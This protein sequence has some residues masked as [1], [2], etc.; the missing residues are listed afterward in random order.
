MKFAR[1]NRI[2]ICIEEFETALS[3]EFLSLKIT[4]F[5]DINYMEFVL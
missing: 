3:I 5:T 4:D 2:K 1:Y